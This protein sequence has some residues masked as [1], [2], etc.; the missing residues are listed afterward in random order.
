MK[1]LKNLVLV[2]LFTIVSNLSMNAQEKHK[3]KKHVCTE[4]CHKEG[5]CVYVHEEKG[6]K[7]DDN[8][9]KTKAKNDKKEKV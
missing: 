4:T 5:K 7:C 8:C 9:K 1:N 2:L 6:H 3:L